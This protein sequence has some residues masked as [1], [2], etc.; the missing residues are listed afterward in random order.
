MVVYSFCSGSDADDA[1]NESAAL[2]FLSRNVR[3]YCLVVM[4]NSWNIITFIR[5][6]AFGCKDMQR[7]D[8]CLKGQ[9]CSRT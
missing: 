8:H 5:P 6:P 9:K 1:A 7:M 3:M 2:T 4:T